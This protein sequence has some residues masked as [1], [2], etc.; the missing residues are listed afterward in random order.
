MLQD[1]ALEVAFPRSGICR[2]PDK[3]VSEMEKVI[4]EVENGKM[5]HEGISD[6]LVSGSRPEGLALDN[7]WGHDIVDEDTMFLY[8]GPLG[9][10]VAGG[11]RPK[12]NS[13]LDFHTEGCPPAYCKLEVTGPNTC[14]LRKYGIDACV[15]RTGDKC[16]LNTH[17][18]VREMRI[19][20]A[21]VAGPAAQNGPADS[22]TALVC[23][24]THPNLYQ[25][26]RSRPRQWPPASLITA[27]LQ[28][29]MLLVLVGHKLSRD[30][31]LQAR[32]SWS[33]LELKLIKMLSESVRQG[34]IAC[35]YVMKRFLKAH[36]GQNEAADGRSLVGSYHIKTVFLRHLE[37]TPPSRIFSPFG[38]FIDIL[39]ELD[40][41][42]KVGKLPHYFLTHCDLFE[43]VKDEELRIAR[44]VIGRILSDPLNALLTCPSRPEQIYGA[45]RPDDLVLRFHRVSS[46]PTCG[47]CLKDLSELL[48]R[49]DERRRERYKVQ[50]EMDGDKKEYKRVSGR[51]TITGL[52]NTI[53]QIK[54][55]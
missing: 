43:T 52:V 40:L 35:K 15:R 41:Y 8:G 12:G 49:V 36:R 10:Y 21:T 51:P 42:L 38:L 26:F 14:S 31:H 53:K 13:C 2:M 4:S 45:V 39:R 18:A 47:Q 5:Y 27:L 55:N 50:Q 34:Y 54:A 20:D 16:W 24:S 32:I 28:L 9:V 25:E 23:S 22:V 46:H 37:K 11:Q 6:C 29:P 44:Q 17:E 48:A 19:T 1:V 33:I 30:V 3:D 7:G